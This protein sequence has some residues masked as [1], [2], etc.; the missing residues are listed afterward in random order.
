MAIAGNRCAL[1]LR[2]I[3]SINY[4][5]LNRVNGDQQPFIF[6]DVVTMME[7]LAQKIV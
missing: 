5:D 2:V 1:L 3:N 7:L 4:K 6:A